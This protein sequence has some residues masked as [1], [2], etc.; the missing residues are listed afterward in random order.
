MRSA[1]ALAAATVNAW[2]R[3]YT[4]G[5][6]APIREARRDEIASDLWEHAKAGAEEGVG[7]RA[8]AGQMLARCLLGIGADLSWR[9]QVVLGQRRAVEKEVPMSDVVKRNWWIPGPILMIGCGIAVGLMSH[10]AR[11]D[12]G[13]DPSPLDI[14]GGVALAGLV[15]VVLPIVA[16]LVRRSHPGW[17]FWMLAPGAIVVLSPLLWLGDAVRDFGGLIIAF[18]AV[19]ILTLVGALTNLAQA[20]VAEPAQPS[21]P[22]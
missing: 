1:D 4:V 10:A 18:V 20:S 19:G 16:L 22:A 13:W 7:S 11:I 14:A 21:S 8:V 15:F 12:K 2:T 3:V 9:V 5:A 17:T 6:A